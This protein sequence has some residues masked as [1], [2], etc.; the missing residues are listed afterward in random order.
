MNKV[1]PES[2]V[3]IIKSLDIDDLPDSFV[4]DQ[5]LLEQGL[6]S[7]DMMSLYF[8]LE[9]N[10]GFVLNDETLSQ[11]DWKTI[12]DFVRN[13]NMQVKVSQG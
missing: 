6:D 5:P 4:Y 3:E 1:T 11:D 2:I 8:A 7:L 13:L 12:D 10:L 9:E